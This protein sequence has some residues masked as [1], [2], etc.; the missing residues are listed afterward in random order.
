MR[1]PAFWQGDRW[2]ARAL[3]PA[4]CLYAQAAAWRQRRAS[5]QRAAVPVVC[6]G[7]LVSGGAGKTP[8]A[9]A[10]ARAL[11][12]EGRRPVF[13]TR[14]YGG[15]TKGPLRVDPA[16]H[17]AALVGDEPLLLA[18]TA[19]VVV[20]ADR[21]A[22]ARA[23][24]AAG[25]DVVVMDDGFQNP[26]LAKDLSI[27]VF[28]AA[29]GLGNGR[30]LPAGPLRE[31]PQA[32]LARAQAL[33]VVGEEPDTVVRQLGALAPHLPLL[34]ARLEPT[35]PAF[36]GRRVL[37]FAGIGRPQK[38]FDSLLRS[39]AEL[40]ATR[41]FPD[42]HR[43]RPAELAGLRSE[44]ARLQATL[45]TTEKDLVRLPPAERRGIEAL[46]VELVFAD[47]EA[48]ARLLAPLLSASRP[49]EPSLSDPT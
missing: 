42:H 23:A 26:H 49:P 25:A 48:L 30:V 43:Y 3:G 46:A 44:A 7:N 31:R 8:T 18:G 32:A 13:L 36:A 1:P 33:L 14:G 2:I 45:V 34:S 35:G 5:P 10:V 12:A 37:A 24:I 19:P 38:F 21:V 6:I 28:D 47:R 11:L 4:S 16:A 40:V 17:N 22:G 29:V 27:L 9:L 41:A 15:R 39:G 20:S